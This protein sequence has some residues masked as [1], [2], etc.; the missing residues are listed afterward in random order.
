MKKAMM[1]GL[2]A[3]AAVSTVSAKEPVE[4]TAEVALMSS[5]IWRGQVI[6]N[7]PVMQPQLT[8]AQYGVSFNIWG[9][10]DMDRNYSGQAGD[11]S[12]IDL[13]LA[14]TLPININQM[15]IDVGVISYQFPANDGGGGESTAEL[16]TT[17]TLQSIPFVIPS[18]TAYGDIKSVDGAYFLMDVVA[19]FEISEYLSV[20]GGASVGY[21]ST[22]YNSVYWSQGDGEG[23]NDFNL[24]ANAKYEITE[25]V[26]VSATVG[27]TWVDGARWDN[28]VSYEAREKFF[29][30]VNVA[31]DF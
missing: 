15:S 16:F 20:E 10:W 29:G 6:N 12:E 31:Y 17:V 2:V 13:S 4:V 9:N 28:A 30:G 21:G 14:Y 25:D 23:F 26:S 18:F 24:Y 11:F 1:F 27:Y 19:P 7:G 3:M 8:L 22:R 5:Y